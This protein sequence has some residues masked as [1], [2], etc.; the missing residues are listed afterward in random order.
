MSLTPHA[1]NYMAQ[2]A[3]I[4]VQHTLPCHTAHIN[5]QGVA[6]L[7]VI[8]NHCCQQVVGSGNSMEITGKMQVDILH[9]HHLGI[10][11]TCGTALQA[12]AWPQGWLTECHSHL[13]ALL[14]Q[15]ISQAYAGGSLALA[16]RR[17]IDSRY[18]NQLTILVIFYL[19]PGIQGNLGL[20][21]AVHFQIV[22]ANV[23]FGSN[24]A[25]VLHLSFLGD[26]NIS[27]HKYNSP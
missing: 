11:A 21:L 19:V 13:L 18:K 10:A 2:G 17:R 4:Q 15:G 9:R 24:L 14:V 22:L 1:D 25:N 23:E 7:D 8:V 20:V 26:F 12:E 3:V 5:I 27:F 6:L 16:G